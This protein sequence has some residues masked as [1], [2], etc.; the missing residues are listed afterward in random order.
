LTA[1]GGEPVR[2]RRLAVRL[3]RQ[4]RVETWNVEMMLGYRQ[5]VRAKAIRAADALD[6]RAALTARP[7]KI[8]SLHREEAIKSQPSPCAE[9]SCRI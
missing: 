3:R 5:Q 6:G 8:L 7:T 2:I 9:P 4:N 1:G